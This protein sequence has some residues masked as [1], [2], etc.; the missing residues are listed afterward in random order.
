MKLSSF[1]VILLFIIII[2]PVLL[3]A[4]NIELVYSTYFGGD[5]SA[6]VSSI[7]LNSAGCAY[8]GGSIMDCNFPIINP[9]QSN[10]S[11]GRDDIYISKF[12]SSGS[13][14]I[15]STYFGGSGRDICNDLIVDC[16]SVYVTGWTQSDNFPTLNSYQDSRSGE[17]D[18]FISK[19]SSTG[20]QLVYSTYFG[21]TK[22]DKGCGISI[23]QDYAYITGL[24]DSIDF[25]TLN[26]YQTKR[27]EWWS[28]FISKLSPSGS[29]IIY[30]TYFGGNL[31]NSV[32]GIA[33]EDE[34][35]YIA[36]ATNSYD[37]PTLDAYQTSRSG[38]N[39]PYGATIQ[40]DD[41]D[42]YVSKLSSSGSMVIFSTYIGGSKRE[43]L[44]GISVEN[45]SIYIGGLTKSEDYPISGFAYQTNQPSQNGKSDAIISKISSSGSKLVFSTY[46]GGRDN[47]IIY[48]I[49][50]EEGCAY[51]TG[52]TQSDNFPTL[53]SYQYRYAGKW[54]NAFVTKLGHDGSHLVFS[55]YLG[56]SKEDCGND[57]A[58]KSGLIYIA[59]YT[60]S[61]DFPTVNPYQSSNNNPEGANIFISKLAVGD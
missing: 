43:D 5:C 6:F 44:S 15:F 49:S 20:S 42:A 47:D 3:L 58:V 51:V 1:L 29:Q 39:D 13:D 28:V 31:S 56:G 45:N 9:Y 17:S 32:C 40:L 11:G 55:T 57:I 41:W 30:S 18:A 25:P 61:D 53:H 38:R 19:L 12:S 24:T 23:E 7:A 48:G 10:Y 21:G 4:Q 50:V 2:Y 35:A 37:F 14:L 60:T 27:N 54:G 26:A 16:E 52:R 33:A 36:G 46:L 22:A 59:G 8:I 34:F